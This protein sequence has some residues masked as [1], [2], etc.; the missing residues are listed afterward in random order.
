M[1]LYIAEETSL[2]TCHCSRPTVTS[3]K[4]KKAVFWLPN[5]GLRQLR[6]IGH[7]LEQAEPHSIQ[8]CF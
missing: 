4:K 2:A 5:A 1:I 7:L 3:E 8:P 6:C